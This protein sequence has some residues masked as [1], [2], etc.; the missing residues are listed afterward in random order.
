MTHADISDAPTPTITTKRQ[1]LA[2]ARRRFGKTAEVRDRGWCF[3]KH[4]GQLAGEPRPTTIEER[5]AIIAR[6]DAASAAFQA[7]R[8]TRPNCRTWPQDD[9]VANF[10]AA[11]DAFDARY[12][13]LKAAES[14]LRNAC[15]SLDRYEVVTHDGFCGHIRGSGMTWDA[16]FDNAK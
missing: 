14:D 5:Q 10:R 15:F 6:R 12:T 8:Q 1:A 9:I 2:E 7:H 3:T 13:E 16:M 11:M 4:Y